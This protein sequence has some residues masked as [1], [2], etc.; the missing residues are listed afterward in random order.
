MRRLELLQSKNTLKPFGELVLEYNPYLDNKGLLW[1]MHFLL[2]SNALLVLWSHAFNQ[3][4]LHEEPLSIQEATSGYDVL[5]GRWSDKTLKEKTPNELGAI[6]RSYTEG[7]FAQLRL[8]KKYETG[9]YEANSNTDLIHPSIWLASILIYRDRYYPE[10]PS[11][12]IPLVVDAHYSP[13]R[14]FRQSELATRRALD[15][16]HNAG[17]LTVETRSGLDQIRFKR[18]VNWLSTVARYLSGG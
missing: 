14:L 12:E 1:L 11:L 5:R 16:L 8:L 15:E 18:E 10:V 13:G 3:M 6:F 17:L 9:I 4:L 7:M 2:A